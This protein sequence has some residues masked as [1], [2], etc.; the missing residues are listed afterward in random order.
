MDALDGPTFFAWAWRLA[1]YGVGVTGKQ[2]HAKIRDS[3]GVS[4]PPAAQRETERVIA[5][6]P[7]AWATD[8]DLAGLIEYRTG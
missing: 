2:I 7:E 1:V 3:E 5:S 4:S 6:T 8:P